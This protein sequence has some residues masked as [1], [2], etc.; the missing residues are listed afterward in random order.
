MPA[1]NYILE[2]TMDTEDFKSKSLD[3]LLSL[4]DAALQKI[5]G[6]AQEPAP[7][8]IAGLIPP[9]IREKLDLLQK[10][11][12]PRHQAYSEQYIEL[13]KKDQCWLSEHK[14]RTGAAYA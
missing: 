1:L 14:N 10:A 3:D 8:E 12:D 6:G 5:F 2:Y 11:G 9:L 7:H 4:Y 13:F